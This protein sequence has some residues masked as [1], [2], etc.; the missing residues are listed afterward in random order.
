M[1]QSKRILVVVDPTSGAQ[2]AAELGARLARK[3]GAV[4]EL[5]ICD[6]DQYLAGERFFDSAA[7]RAA[8]KSLIDNHLKK[9]NKIASKLDLDAAAVEVDATWDRPLDE[10]I[11]RKILASK[12][13]LVIKDTHY[14]SALKRSIFSNTDWNL[15]R[16]CP[17]ALLL[18]KPDSAAASGAVIAAVDPVHERDKPAELD[19]AILKAAR[20]LS[21]ELGGPLHVVHGF[22][23]S[24]AYAVS[25]DSM[26]FPIA[27]P[28]HE[29]TEALRARHQDAVKELVEPYGLPPGNVHVVE[30][31][32]RKILVGLAEK[33]GAS[34]VVMGA[35]A[36]GPLKRL[37]LGSTAEQ[38]L[39][40]LPSNLLIVKPA[41]F[42]TSVGPAS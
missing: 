22:D 20:K 5:F 4:L 13:A 31:E 24:P 30:G 16:E 37:V 17:A 18:V 40:R 42:E 25:A 29:M 15:I 36:R 12:P 23:P 26:A 32:T 7:L 35:I 3:T 33:L 10:G 41:G 9:L 39:D 2:P 1:N 21:E 28:I 8:R 11:V 6:Y 27:T 38:V 19:H 34:V 14:H